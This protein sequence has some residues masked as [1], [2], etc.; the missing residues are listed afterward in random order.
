VHWLAIELPPLAAGTTFAQGFRKGEKGYRQRDAGGLLRGDQRLRWVSTECW[1]KD[2]LSGRGRLGGGLRGKRIA[3][4]GAGALGS[5]MGELLVR[6]GVDDLTIFDGD[7]FEAGNLVRHTLGL[8]QVGAKKAEALARRLD[9][10]APSATLHGVGQV[11]PDPQVDC[12]SMDIILDATGDED[13]LD[14]LER[15]PWKH[16]RW[17]ASFWVGMHA[18][19]VYCFSSWGRCFPAARCRQLFEPRREREGG[20]YSGEE[21]PRPGIGCWHPV[22][23]ARAD[24]IWL[25]AAILVKYLDRILASGAAGPTLAVFEQSEDPD[26]PGIRRVQ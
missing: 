2:E 17:F 10:A 5:A 18:R 20:E 13:V 12:D 15:Y 25:A 16:D 24:D 22:F 3:L 14:H 21:P 11:F 8:G 1:D 9:E 4:L 7:A 19:R 23:P 6:G 26:S